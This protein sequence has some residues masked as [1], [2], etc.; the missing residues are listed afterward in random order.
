[1]GLE[2]QALD[3]AERTESSPGD[4][5]GPVLWQQCDRGEQ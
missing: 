5:G 4:L 2:R 1:M 3:I